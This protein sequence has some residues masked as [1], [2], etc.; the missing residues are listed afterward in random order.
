MPLDGDAPKRIADAKCGIVVEPEN[1]GQVCEAILRLYS[2]QAER[3]KMG[4][5]GRAYAEEHLSI[6]KCVT[7][8][9]RLLQE[10][11]NK[12]GGARRIAKENRRN[13]GNCE[14]SHLVK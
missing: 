4:R 3:E 6:K 9:E 5:D 7:N 13:E 10:L 11:V 12:R 2:D 14:I 8:I 1:P